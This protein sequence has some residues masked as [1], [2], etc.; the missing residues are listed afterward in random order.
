M[1]GMTIDYEKDLA[2]LLQRES[3]KHPKGGEHAD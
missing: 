3:V 1:V 2:L